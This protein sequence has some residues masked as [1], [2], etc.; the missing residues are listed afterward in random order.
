MHSL[1]GAIGCICVAIFA[2]VFGFAGAATGPQPAVDVAA[3]DGSNA[4]PLPQTQPDPVPTPGSDAPM[5]RFGP[6]PVLIVRPTARPDIVVVSSP[7]PETEQLQRRLL[8][9]QRRIL[10]FVVE[11]NPRASKRALRNYPAVLLSEAARSNI[12]HCLA[13][14]QAQTESDFT[15]DAVGAAGEIGLYQMLPST[16]ALFEPTVGKLRQPDLKKHKPDLGSLADPVVSTRFAMAYLRDILVRKPRLR[17]ALTE[18]NGGPRGRKPEYYR[19]VMANYVE[20]LE[21]P[22]LGCR[23]RERHGNPPVFAVPS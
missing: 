5:I 2:G 7:S 16:A 15:P 21:R 11:M 14:A 9:L 17:D 1:R 8:E 23:I 10:E 13:L 19:I 18:Y 4:Q 22:E 12:D 6:D 3:A 20:I